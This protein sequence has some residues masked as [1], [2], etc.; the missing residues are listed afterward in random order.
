LTEPQKAV[1][2]SPSPSE[3]AG[4]LAPLEGWPD[5]TDELAEIRFSSIEGIDD[6]TRRAVAELSEKY[7]G[8]PEVIALVAELGGD[9]PSAP[10]SMEGPPPRGRYPVDAVKGGTAPP[11]SESTEVSPPSPETEALVGLQRPSD[12][13]EA[14]G[15]GAPMP[16]V[17]ETSD[18][19]LNLS[20]D[21][22]E[23]D[24]LEDDEEA[25]ETSAVSLIEQLDLDAGTA[26]APLSPTPY[27]PRSST[28]PSPAVSGP[29]EAEEDDI[30]LEIE[31]VAE[32][33]VVE[34]EDDF[35]D[36]T[37]MVQGYQPPAPYDDEPAPFGEEGGSTVTD[38]RKLEDEDIDRGA[39]TLAPGGDL[40]EEDELETT[41][42][43]GQYL[44]GGGA[45]SSSAPDDD[46]A[47]T[48]LEVKPPPV[49]V[50]V[51]RKSTV[52]PDD[53]QRAPSPAPYSGDSAAASGEFSVSDIGLDE[54]PDLGRASVPPIRAAELAEE[55]AEVDEEA[56]T[57]EGTVVA[58]AP[59]PPSPY[60][61]GDA[62]VPVVPVRLA[63]LGTRG[64]E[65]AERRIEAGAYLDLGRRPGEPWAEDR[66]MQPLHARVFPAPGG[67]IIDDFGA[68][69]GVYTQILDT[70]AVEDGDEFKVGQARLALQRVTSP[71]GTW[72]QLTL[73]RHEK[74][75]PETFRLDRDEIF[76]GREDGDITL[77]EDTFVSG[78]HCRFS[79]E[80]NAVYL[81]DLGSSN[82][83]YVRVRAGQC[84]AFGGLLLIGHTQFRVHAG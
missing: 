46:A 33:D 61:L 79:R 42:P 16:A 76:I 59:M 29:S 49:P 71:D 38:L 47:P 53:G 68:P 67:V 23:F 22:A 8:H 26:D 30:S 65:V 50:A 52:I 54:M 11:I 58:R 75:T 45:L 15:L 10:I 7:P 56:F 21:V 12:L 44:I 28:A 70:I 40:R 48:D 63:M 3:T 27:A 14:E 60:G 41:L 72:G 81:E 80:G 73:V 66:R 25:Y 77:P 64:E 57:V 9:A 24:R 83:T 34:D 74:P 51:D 13:V 6:D 2:A 55:L 32:D 4:I 18:E 69:H 43:P 37:M 82:G 84:V 39:V 36:R 5:V 62:P 19:L 1:Y 78:D 20:V 35:V 17:M 31:D